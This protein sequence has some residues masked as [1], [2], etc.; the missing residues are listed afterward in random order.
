MLNIA[1]KAARRAG[2][3]IN[4]ASF[5]VGGLTVTRKRHNDYV[6]E[7]DHAA[8]R[9]ILDV[10]TEAY[11]NHGI[12]A[13]E[14]GATGSSSSEY[15]WVID[16][17]DGTTNFMHGVP[18]YAVSIA[19]LHREVITQAVVYDPA[20]NE[21]YTASRGRGAY[22]N[23][24]RLRVSKTA[25]LKDGL[26]STGFPFRDLA[27]LD[28]YMAM[29]RAVTEHSSGVRRPGAAALDLAW[30]ASGRFDG[31]WEM[32]LAAWDLAAGALLITEAGGMI[33]DVDGSDGYLTSGNVVCGNPKVFAELL[34]VVS[35]HAPIKPTRQTTEIVLVSDLEEAQAKASPVTRRRR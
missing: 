26:I 25:T 20:R 24:R 6:T 33:A 22:M 30:V 17:L 10:L 8:E 7:V 35:P 4:R 29:F 9:A 28:N 34:K 19:L 14:S 32:G 16:P 12:L 13:E 27:N 23:D 5:D 21:L 31:F 11:P 18:Q 1:V 3:L 2:A 15:Q